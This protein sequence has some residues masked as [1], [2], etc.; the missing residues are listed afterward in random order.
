[1]GRGARPL[2]DP[3]SASAGRASSVHGL[4][5]GGVLFGDD[6]A[7]ELLRG[8]ELP[9]GHGELGVENDELLHLL[10][11]RRR[12]RVGAVDAFLDGLGDLGVCL[13]LGDRGGGRADRLHREQ[14]GC[15]Q[16][17][18]RLRPDLGRLHH[19]SQREQARE[20]LALVSDEHG[21]AHHRALQLDLVLD[22]DG[23]HVLASRRDDE[24]LDAARDRQ[25]RRAAAVRRVVKL[26]KVARPEE[27]RLVERL[28]GLLLFVE[29]PHHHVAAPH[30]HLPVPLLAGGCEALALLEV[31]L[32]VARRRGYADGAELGLRWEGR[33][34]HVA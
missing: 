6:V 18:G 28:R 27:A 33:G 3:D 31:E 10:R 26:A 21:V 16:L 34:R 13:G 19:D 23:R 32:D 2:H 22:E 14:A 25:H 7:L 9:S 24:L 30:A 20:E 29:V 8:G 15:V 1:M 11:A 12:G 5:F 17:V 4:D